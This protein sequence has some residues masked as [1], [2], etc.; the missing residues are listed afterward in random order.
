MQ[1]Q[2]PREAFDINPLHYLKYLKIFQRAWLP[3]AC[4]FI[5][6]MGLSV[7]AA[8]RVKPIYEAEAKLLFKIDSASRLTGLAQDQT[9]NNPLRSLLVDQSPI[10]NQIEILLSGPLL[11]RTIKK[12]DLRDKKGEPMSAEA[13]RKDLEVKIIGATD[14]VSIT[15]SNE[16]PELTAA[17][18]NTVIDMYRDNNVAITREDAVQAR[19]FL[20]QEL[21]GIEQQ[22]RKSEIQLQRFKE[23]HGVIDL[24]REAEAAVTSLRLL[25]EEI[26]TTQ[27]ALAEADSRTQSLN[28]D[29]GLSPKEAIV[30]AAVSQSTAIQKVLGDLQDLQKD[31][32]QQRAKFT[33]SSP[34]VARLLDRESQLK[35]LLDLRIQETLGRQ[36]NIPP[37]FLQAGPLRTGL[38]AAYLESGTQQLSLASKLKTLQSAR[39]V[40]QR[41]A[42]DLPKLEQEQRYLERKLKAAQGTYETVLGNLQTLLVKEEQRNNITR[43]IEP[44]TT[45]SKGSS[46]GKTKIL[47]LGLL[48]STFF[49][50]AIIVVAEVVRSRFKSEKA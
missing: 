14:I 15:Y 31:L 34:V 26:A 6:G 35:Q 43:I 40:Y 45:P 25:D 21:P 22:L 11:E 32:T 46:A 37:S 8:R 50:S 16:S 38:I 27:A 19:L 7:W 33:D 2:P 39:R 13:L 3:A 9:D 10:S 44:A 17:V 24:D 18:I 5:L 49:S 30:V 47:A 29:L 12:L 42:Q 41:R 23:R 48:G 4:V 1:S 20:S 28:S 36:K